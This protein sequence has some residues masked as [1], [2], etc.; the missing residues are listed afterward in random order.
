LLADS[1]EFTQ[2]NR[3]V[4]ITLDDVDWGQVVDGLECRAWQYDRTAHYYETGGGDECIEE[5]NSAEE[6]RN[7]AKWYRRI[8]KQIRKQ[9]GDG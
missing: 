1:R 6:A 3:Q 8:S 2:M 5:V 7:L 9:L 4:T